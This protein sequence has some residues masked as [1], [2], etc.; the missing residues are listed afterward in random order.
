MNGASA[1]GLGGLALVATVLAVAVVGTF[2]A[3]LLLAV[4]SFLAWGIL[5]VL[6]PPQREL[7]GIPLSDA[8]RQVLELGV[9]AAALLFAI[10]SASQASA[11]LVAGGGRS[12]RWVT[13]AARIDPG[14]YRL[15][16]LLAGTPGARGPC[17]RVRV[18]G[19]AAHL[20]FPHHDA[21]T[22]LL[23]S[24]GVRAGE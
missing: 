5:G 23:R 24:C 20:L 8:R 2:D 19:R 3:V 9:A 16:M 4:P 22:R 13:W 6:L 12:V 21:P 15:Q 7:V 1:E 18:N 10:R 11:I 17:S 14:S